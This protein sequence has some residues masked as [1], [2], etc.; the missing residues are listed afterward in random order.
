MTWTSV[1]RRYVP[2]DREVSKHLIVIG[3]QLDILKEFTPSG[4]LQLF[5]Y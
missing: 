4:L 2:G 1:K 3:N 5:I